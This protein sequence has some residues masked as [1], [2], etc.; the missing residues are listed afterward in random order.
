MQIL[1]N[2]LM[3]SGGNS[4][5]SDEYGSAVPAPEIKIGI[6]Y[7]IDL[8]LRAANPNGDNAILAPYP[9]QELSAASG[10][11]LAIDGDWNHE[12]TPKLFITSGISLYQDE[13]GHTHLHAS[14]PNTAQPGILSAV[15]TAKS[16]SLLCEIG[17]YAASG[18]AAD[19]VF[20]FDFS[21]TIRNRIYI[22][23]EVPETV[24]NDPEYL[25]AAQ[26]RAVIADYLA[27]G[28]SIGTVTSG[29]AA[30]ASISGSVPNQQLNLVLPK[31]ETGG[32]GRD[33]QDG[34]D[35]TN[36]LTPYIDPDTKNW[37][38]G[39]HDTEVCAEGKT[40]PRG[41]GME[42]D[43]SG[44][45]ADKALYDDE[46]AGF[47][48]AA[49]S[50][51]STAKT[52]TLYIW[53]KL[54]S[55]SADWSDALTFVFYSSDSVAVILEPI[56]FDPPAMDAVAEYFH[57]SMTN[58]P[59]A[60][61]C[62]VA[63]DTADGE[64]ILPY[65]S[66]LGVKKI[67]KIGTEC[68]IYFGSNIPAYTRGR[69]YLS[70]FVAAEASGSTN[71]GG[72]SPTWELPDEGIYYGYIPA[73]DAASLNSVADITQDMIDDAVTAGTV[74]RIEANALNQSVT[75]PKYGWLFVALP[76]GSSLVAKKDDGF[77]NQVA[78]AEDNG[79]TGTSAS[80]LKFYGEFSLVSAA[81]TLYVGGAS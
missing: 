80:N 5:I 55:A 23:D 79:T 65:Y 40:G 34:I 47:K 36:G 51:N 16:I 54:S 49:T 3:I 45:L 59:N 78:F 20:A 30:D 71:I 44:S 43:A 69:I 17:G 14:L 25:T 42:F 63:L 22:G 56:E 37:R 19:A 12:T 61:V 77:G 1:K 33:G 7:E 38:I 46:A 64:L 27:A 74:V 70:Q 57:F 76:A 6:A 28:I 53:T 4:S 32:P 72:D 10:F 60:C 81:H 21:L 29:D 73:V 24:E 52:T 8:D 75:V 50:I 9:Y 11:Y 58:Y 66:D 68:Y 35:G 2:I 62:Q 31:G 41:Q 39:N 48:F 15:A 67:L 13:E 26:V 18:S